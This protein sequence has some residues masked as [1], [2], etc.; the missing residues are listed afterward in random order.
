MLKTINYSFN[1]EK[2][3]INDAL[4]DQP[5]M[6]IYGKKWITYYVKKFGIR[7]LF[8]SIQFKLDW[9]VCDSLLKCVPV[10]NALAYFFTNED[11]ETFQ[12]IAASSVLKGMSHKRRWPHPLHALAGSTDG[13]KSFGWKPFCR[14]TFGQ[15]TFGQQT[16]GWQTFGRQTFGRQ[17]FGRHNMSM[18][19]RP[20][21]YP[22]NTRGG[23]ITV[24]LTSCLTGLDESVLEI[25]TKIVT[26]V[27]RL[28]LNQSNRRPT[29]QWYF[30][31]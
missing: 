13:S 7:S 6:N 26:V 9:I 23:S 31:F 1:F 28:I 25:K 17:T 2:I 22:G 8:I 29:V 11:E 20:N 19:F 14:Q 16:F 30:P 3:V 15:Q 4:F 12:D 27:I 10:A 5:L 24:P 21:A 18:V